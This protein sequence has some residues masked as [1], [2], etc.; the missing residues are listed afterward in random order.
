M[1]WMI[2]SRKVFRIGLNGNLQ[3]RDATDE[4]FFAMSDALNDPDSVRQWIPVKERLPEEP[5]EYFATL[6][7]WPEPITGHIIIQKKGVIW[8]KG[9]LIPESQIIAFI[10]P[11]PAP[12]KEDV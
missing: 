5:G 11:L 2:D 10:G 3:Y 8:H 7:S 6:Q 9:T 12:Y 4:E 1:S